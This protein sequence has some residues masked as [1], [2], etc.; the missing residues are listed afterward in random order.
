MNSGKIAARI[1]RNEAAA[2][3]ADNVPRGGYASNKYEMEEILNPM[4]AKSLFPLRTAKEG[5]TM[6]DIAPQTYRAVP[7]MG[8]R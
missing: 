7:K 2:V 1:S 8:L 5:L 4:L 3:S 6:I